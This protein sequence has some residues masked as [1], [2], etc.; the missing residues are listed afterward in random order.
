ME[1]SW[2]FQ[3]DE[4]NRTVFGFDI[5]VDQVKAIGPFL[6]L[7]LIPLWKN[8]LIPL[9]LS[10]N[11]HI[12]PLESIGMGGVS[13]SLSFFCAAILQFNIEHFR[14]EN[15]LSILWQIPQYLLLMLGEVWLSL[16]GLNF[17]FTQSPSSMKSVMTAAWFCNC[18]FGNLIVIIITELQLFD[19]TQ[20][21]YQFFLYAFLMFIAILFY[22]WIAIDTKTE[23][24]VRTDEI[25]DDD[26]LQNIRLN[27]RSVKLA[28][29]A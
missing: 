26:Y 5:K 15:Q 12:S 22:S 19:E 14:D 25:S 4:L 16:P 7:I 2:T 21:G 20:K 23:N 18:A 24:D 6:L 17:S 27:N 3:A 8:L 11:I 10:Y 28:D 29:G 9:L 13:A 1:S